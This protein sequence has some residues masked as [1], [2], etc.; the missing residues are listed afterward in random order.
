MILLFTVCNSLI[1]MTRKG[2]IQKKNIFKCELS[3]AGIYQKKI[4]IFCNHR[5]GYYV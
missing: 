3:H 4:E 5:K 1:I 2:L